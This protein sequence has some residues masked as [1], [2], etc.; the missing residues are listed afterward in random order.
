M[1]DPHHLRGCVGVQARRRLVEEDEAGIGDELD[2]D[3]GTL[4][5]TAGDSLEEGAADEGV[6]ALGELEVLDD[7]VHSLQ[8]LALGATQLESRRKLEALA[9][10]HRLE[11][12]VILLHVG[13]QGRVTLDLGGVHAVDLDLALLGQV[14]G[15]QSA[16][17]V[18]QEGRLSRARGSQDTDEHSGHGASG[19]P[20]QNGLGDALAGF[21]AT[22]L[23][24]LGLDDDVVPRDLDPLLDLLDLSILHL[25]LG[26][27]KAVVQRVVRVVVHLLVFSFLVELQ[28]TPQIHLLL[29]RGILHHLLIG[30]EVLQLSGWLHR[31]DSIP[32]SKALHVRHAIVLV[33]FQ[34]LHFFYFKL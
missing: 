17:D 10:G 29:L 11:Q 13:R 24:R 18:V 9:H 31:L 15:D 3:R 26:G 1:Q 30:G 21:A 16:R 5:L 14:L 27:V 28:A 7:L 8:L 25:V 33:S 12:Y 20:V 34:L 4:A 32:V 23:R 19:E 22:A 6:L 2:S